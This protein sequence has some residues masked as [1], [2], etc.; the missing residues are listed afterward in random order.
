M[1]NSSCKFYITSTMH[2]LLG[3]K[4]ELKKLDLVSR[5][6]YWPILHHYIHQ[7]IDKCDL[8][9]Q[10]KSIHHSQNGL[11]QPI[12][13]THA[14]WKQISTNFIVKLLYSNGYDSIM[15][16]VDRNTKMA[17]FIPTKEIINSMEIASLYLYNIWKLYGTPKE[18]ISDCGL[19][20]ISKFMKRLC[21]SLRIQPSPTT[22]FHPQADDQ[23]D[24]PS[25]RAVSSNFHH[26]PSERLG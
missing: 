16:V 24:Q 2:Q 15:V 18:V 17:D 10:S 5:I 4:G 19:V 11:M 23:T 21:E 26:N 6:F 7:Y 14:P 1:R 22:T 12:S 25:P 13:A 20:F 3:T 9:Q 8:C